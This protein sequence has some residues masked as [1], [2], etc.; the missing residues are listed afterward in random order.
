MNRDTYRK[1]QGKSETS[2]GASRFKIQLSNSLPIRYPIYIPTFDRPNNLTSRELSRLKVPHTV[3][4]KTH[5][6]TEFKHKS[7]SVERFI[8]VDDRTFSSTEQRNA[9]LDDAQKNGHEYA[10][11]FDDNIR[12]FR[13][14]SEGRKIHVGRD[15]I[16]LVEQM[17]ACC[18]NVAIGGMEY[19]HH[20]RPNMKKPAF[21]MNRLIY[22]AML[23]RV[24]YRFE[25]LWNEDVDICIRA[26]Q[27]GHGTFKTNCVTCDKVPTGRAKGG[28]QKLYSGKG[29]IRK[30]VYLRRKYPDMVNIVNK[31]GR[32]AHQ[33]KWDN[34]PNP[35]ILVDGIEP[36]D[37]FFDY[38]ASAR[39][40]A[41]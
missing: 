37:I 25:G 21:M 12:T 19:T 33:M 26:M 22:S 41:T 5:D 39:V 20:L 31:Y 36:Q 2:K 4:K 8:D 1:L 10:W 7:E 23:V 9:A 40:K 17:M 18:E 3:V 16:S 14:L 35:E 11:L 15:A 13:L 38:M 6:P 32:Y 24:D 30:T 27:N 28:N 29:H 34:V